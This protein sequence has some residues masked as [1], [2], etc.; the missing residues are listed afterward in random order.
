[1]DGPTF[2]HIW[3]VLTGLIRLSPKQKQNT[4][5]TSKQTTTTKQRHEV[6]KT[7]VGENVEEL[8]REIKEY[9]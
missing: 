3:A 9:I 4:H 2:M 6:G 7:R 1:M 5:K 8:E